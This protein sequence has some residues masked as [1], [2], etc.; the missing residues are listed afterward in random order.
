MSA[1]GVI[2]NFA[3]LVKFKIS[4]D[5]SDEFAVLTAQ[6]KLDMSRD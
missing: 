5:L 6:E 3:K 4:G 2:Q 1:S